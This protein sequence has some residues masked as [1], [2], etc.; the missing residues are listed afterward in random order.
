MPHGVTRFPYTSLAKRS[1]HVG[2]PLI[3]GCHFK[4]KQVKLVRNETEHSHYTPLGYPTWPQCKS[5]YSGSI[6]L[7]I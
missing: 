6:T 7:S 4:H 3:R 5:L 2:T 1:E